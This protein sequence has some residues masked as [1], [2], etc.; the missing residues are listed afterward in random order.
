MLK[1]TGDEVEAET[2][3]RT[4]V[5]TMK[6]HKMAMEIV[7]VAV[8]MKDNNEK[9]MI[10]TH[11]NKGTFN[12]YENLPYFWDFEVVEKRN[13]TSKLRELGGIILKFSQAP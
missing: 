11:Q 1:T 13:K 7:V 8:D 4:V 2:T 10:V 12:R 3:T 6:M 9:G 5:F